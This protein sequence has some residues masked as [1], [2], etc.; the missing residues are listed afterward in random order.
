MRIAKK[1]QSE[2][3]KLSKLLYS[4]VHQLQFLWAFT[5]NAVGKTQS[6]TEKLGAVVSNEWVQRKH[7]YI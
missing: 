6:Q 5:G 7:E 3:S 2:V 1:T 4:Y